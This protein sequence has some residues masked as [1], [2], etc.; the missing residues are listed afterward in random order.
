VATIIK[1]N[2]EK[3]K[4]SP[5]NFDEANELLKEIKT[6]SDTSDLKDYTS[7]ENLVEKTKSLSSAIAKNLWLN[8]AGMIHRSQPNSTTTAVF[9]PSLNNKSEEQ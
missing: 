1:D 6:L 5:N 3:W 9:S 4:L 2:Y 7:N 8:R